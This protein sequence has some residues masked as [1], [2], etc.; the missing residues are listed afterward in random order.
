MGTEARMVPP[1][2]EHP[3]R[4]NGRYVPLYGNYKAALEKFEA[5]REEKGL[6]A[7]LDD[8]GCAPCSD[9]YMPYWEGEQC[10]HYMMYETTSEG[11]PISPIF[12]TPE[13][14]ARWLADNKV[15]S[16]NDRTETF[17]QWLSMIR[18]QDFL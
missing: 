6:A 13:E 7:A 5:V 4:E 3:K 8:F 16:F 2:W 1:S 15:R 9:S 12:K 18:A 10:T 17:E 14:L 11:T